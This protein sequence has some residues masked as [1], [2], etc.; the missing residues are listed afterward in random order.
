MSIEQTDMVDIISIDASTGSVVLTIND[1]LDWSHRAAHE[2][3]LQ[4]KL[5]HYLTFI[6]T[7]ELLNVYPT[8]KGRP[9]VTRVV[10]RFPPDEDARRFLKALKAILVSAGLPLEYEVFSRGG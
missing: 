5:H 6:A 8:A 3:L 9:V 2:T 10:L 1:P 4:R 7:G